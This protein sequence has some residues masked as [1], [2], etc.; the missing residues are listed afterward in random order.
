[1]DTLV[2]DV[3]SSCCESRRRPPTSDADNYAAPRV[4]VAD[5]QGNRV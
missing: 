4:L 3:S 1:M 5:Y 2:M